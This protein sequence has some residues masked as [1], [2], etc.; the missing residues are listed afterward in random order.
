MAPTPISACIISMNEADRIGDCL[1]SL[2]FCDEVVV[3]DSHSTDE[4]RALAAAAGA[5]VIERDWSGFTAQKQFAVESATHDWV[6]C[7][8]ADERVE[9][10]LAEEIKALAAQDFPGAAA[11]NMPRLTMWQGMWIRGGTWY[12]DRQLRLFDR[13]RGSW[14]G[15]VVHEKAVINGEVKQL[16]GHLLHHSY[17]DLDDHLGTI[18]K[19]TD[20]GAQKLQAKGRRATYSDLWLR[21]AVRFFRFFIIGRGFMMG[22]RGLSLS[23]L[24][25]HY[26]HLKYLRL[27]ISQR[28]NDQ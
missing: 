13:R 2:D 27:M 15:G 6:L 23:M 20:L 19:Y 1:A 24:A 7:I 3:I 16:G 22:W 9:P 8:D 18:S 14:Q 11:W 17:R 10:A 5:Q 26:V 4:T 28:Q 21:P 12:P 25:A